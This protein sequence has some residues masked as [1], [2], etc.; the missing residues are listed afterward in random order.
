M[1]KQ[2]RTERCTP[3]ERAFL[4][5]LIEGMNLAI[6]ESCFVCP[7]CEYDG[8]SPKTDALKTTLENLELELKDGNR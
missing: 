4:D 3:A 5:A 2:E 1:S 6:P 8:L 7:V